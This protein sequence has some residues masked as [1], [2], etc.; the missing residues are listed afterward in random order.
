M[1][2][3]YAMT[4]PSVCMPEIEHAGVYDHVE[5]VLGSKVTKKVESFCAKH[6]ADTDTVILSAFFALLVKYLDARKTI[7]H[8]LIDSR[9]LILTLQNAQQNNFCWLI[10]SLNGQLRGK[11]SISSSS[12][13]AYP[14]VFV[15]DNQSIENNAGIITLVAEPEDGGKAKMVFDKTAVPRWYVQQ[16]A[17]HLAQLLYRLCDHPYKSLPE[18]ELLSEK[19]QR[20]LLTLAE[21][22]KIDYPTDTIYQLFEKQV[23]A[24]PDRIAVK[25]NSIYGES[26]SIPYRQLHQQV[27]ALAS[28]IQGMV[29]A[30]RQAI[31]V[32]LPRS[33][34][35]LICLLAIAKT[36]GLYVPLDAAFP[37]TYVKQIADDAGLKIIVSSKVHEKD[38]ASLANELIC[39]DGEYETT[40]PPAPQANITIDS[41]LLIMYTSGSTGKPKGVMHVQ[42]QVVNRLHWMWKDY[43]FKATDILGQRSSVNV[44][45]C[46]WEMLGGLLKGITTVIIPT[47][48]QREPK[49]FAQFIFEH[50]ISFITL[51]PSL[52]KAVL[53]YDEC[54]VLLAS[55]RIVIVG[56]E[57][58]QHQLLCRF[59]D[60]IPQ[61]TLVNDFGATEVNTILHAAFTPSQPLDQVNPAAGR[62]ISN[63]SAYILGKDMQLL[64]PGMPGELCVSGH[65]MATGYYKN[66]DQ[67]KKRFPVH[68]LLGRLY[69]TGDM[70]M[71][72]P[73]GQIE[74]KG[75]LDGAIKINGFLVETTQI[76]HAV[77]DIPGVKKCA[78]VARTLKSGKHQLHAFVETIDGN[79]LLGL[80]QQLGEM[81]PWYMLPAAF[82]FMQVLP[83]R[84]NGKTDRV[85]LLEMTDIQ[86]IQSNMEEERSV[87]QTIY[88]YVAAILEIQESAVPPGKPFFD[89]GLDSMGAITL[90]QLLEK[91]Y[92]LSLP[93]STL[94]DHPTPQKLSSHL[95]GLINSITPLLAPQAPATEDSVIKRDTDIA[96]LG[97]SGRFP[98]AA[99]ASAFWKNLL[100]A[101]DCVEEIPAERWDVT[102]IYDPD[103]SKKGKSLSKWAGLLS[104]IDQF[105]PLFFN[106]SPQEARLMDPQHRMMLMEAWNALE[107]AGYTPDALSDLQVGVYIGAKK[108]DYDSLFAEDI[109]PSAETLIGNDAAVLSARLSYFLNFHGPN[110]TIDT[111]CSSSLVAVHLACQAIQNGEIDMA[112]V[113]GVCINHAASFYVATSRLGIFSATGKC[114]AFDNSADGFV[115]GEGAAFVLLR[116][117][118]DAKRNNDYIYGVIK[119]TAVN[120]GGRANGLASPGAAAQSAVQLQAYQR[121]GI[122][123]EN[124]SYVEAHGTGTRLGDP[125]EIDALTQSFRKYTRG[126]QFCGIGSVKTNIGHLTA[127]AGITGLI[128]V[129]LSLRHKVLPPSL[130]F[131]NPNEH[132]RFKESPFYVVMEK[133][134]WKS[135]SGRPLQAAINSFGMGGTNA[136]CVVQEAPQQGQDQLIIP[137]YLVPLS[138]RTPASLLSRI[139]ELHDWLQENPNASL[140]SIAYTLCVGRVFFPFYQLFLVSSMQDLT[141]QLAQAWDKPLF[142]EIQ[143]ASKRVAEQPMTNAREDA[144]QYYVQLLSLK[145]WIEE[146]GRPDWQAL[147]AKTPANRM[148]LPAY[149]FNTQSYWVGTPAIK[150]ADEPMPESTG[151]NGT[152]KEGNTAEEILVNSVARLLEVSMEQLAFSVSL[153]N[154]GFD[155]IKAMTLKYELEQSLKREINMEHLN[156]HNTLDEVLQGIRGA[157]P[158]AENISIQ[159]LVNK[160][161]NDQLEIETVDSA[162]LDKIYAYMEN[163]SSGKL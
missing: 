31:G 34:E 86:P 109:T 118:A 140:H 11:Q 151:G 160:F 42:R 5:I 91:T 159:E 44:M 120:H 36:G 94:F 110:L 77:Q 84:P 57:I 7:L 162:L 146:G 63:I 48:L 156:P 58:L 113:G 97:I 20:Q 61:A 62:P 22:P 157:E 70:G 99:N 82:H 89:I 38:A 102:G 117:L 130:H 122:N 78:V 50:R 33:V 25:G 125:I 126:S 43:P 17:K 138:A 23:A 154:Y 68:P 163:I 72:L 69:R 116:P 100:D 56:G 124:I 71:V 87:L 133:R 155:S 129:L 143:P 45:P 60:R 123:P 53:Q 32:Y 16:W 134:D 112:L 15:A 93:V 88:R 144:R 96:V 127:A 141:G 46:M 90:V 67:T 59:R 14:F 83:L 131:S 39:I 111:A 13:V 152:G 153:A 158:V 6:S 85:T 49:A 41:L 81:L 108:G 1:N 115:H 147:F 75:R 142:L 37:L 161:L 3:V 132:I 145:A 121:Y 73:G 105:E 8:V 106:L 40:M 26:I 74:M 2:K 54:A 95:L 101:R 29:M 107:D 80:R 51:N 19:E 119:A 4:L 9:S 12:D 139:K 35:S 148:P 136:H 21:G 98:K 92:K 64:P 24:S 149:S 135:A 47:E 30:G 65:S 79:S 27:E 103:P 10:D 104:G 150:K 128:K 18:I 114:R 28:K 76:E 52:L 137:W 55:L 66:E